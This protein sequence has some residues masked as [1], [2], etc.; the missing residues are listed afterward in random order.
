MKRRC[1]FPVTVCYL[2][3]ACLS[4]AG[5]KTYTVEGEITFNGTGNIFVSLVTEELFGKKYEGVREKILVVTENESGS[6]RIRFSFDG[7]DTG[8]YGIRCYQDENEN[9][10]LDGGLFG[11]TEP[12]GMSFR[13][14]RPTRWP[15]FENISFEV[16][17]DVRDLTIVLK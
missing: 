17:E 16:I 1:L 14:D 9:G 5:T 12:W 8:V 15:T 3:W 11:P 6:G 2:F 13:H 7:V 10:E 4:F